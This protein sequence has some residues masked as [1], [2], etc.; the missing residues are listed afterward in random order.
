MA[1]LIR[2]DKAL[3]LQGKVKIVEPVGVPHTG[4]LK[5]NYAGQ[6]AEEHHVCV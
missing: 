3:R 6:V 4:G 5:G 2:Q 1:R